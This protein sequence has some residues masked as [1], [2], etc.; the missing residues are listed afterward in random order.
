MSTGR[1]SPLRRLAVLGLLGACLIAAAPS[2]AAMEGRLKDVAV[3]PQA[4]LGLAFPGINLKNNRLLGAG[5]LG[6]VHS[7]VHWG[8]REPRPGRYD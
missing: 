5:G 3:K 4:R 2:R 1:P 7:V 6:V 8:R